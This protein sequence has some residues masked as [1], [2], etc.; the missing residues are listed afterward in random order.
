[1]TPVGEYVD[2]AD[3]V[4]GEESC[5]NRAPPEKA[6]KSIG[7]GSRRSLD[8]TVGIEDCRSCDAD[9]LMILHVGEHGPEKT[10]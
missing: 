7:E 3:P 2:P 10:P 4:F 1:M 9:F 6:G 8:R 5:E